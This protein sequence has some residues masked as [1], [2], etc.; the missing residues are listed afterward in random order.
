MNDAACIPFAKPWT[1]CQ[2]PF[3]PSSGIY[4]NHEKYFHSIKL[5]SISLDLFSILNTEVSPQTAES[6]SKTGNKA[7]QDTNEGVNQ[8]DNR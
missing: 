5:S 2:Q 6:K 7:V 4:D 8:A 1:S 3:P